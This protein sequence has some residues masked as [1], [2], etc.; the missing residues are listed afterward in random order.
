MS[1]SANAKSLVVLLQAARGKKLAVRGAVLAQQLGLMGGPRAVRDLLANERAGILAEL[2]PSVLICLPPAGYWL[3]TSTD[4]I[5][6]QVQQWAAAERRERER[7][8][9]FFASVKRAG[10]L[11]TIK[12][13]F[14]RERK[15]AA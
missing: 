15:E 14:R 3:A 8:R 7:K 12:G 1:L 6:E 11:G 10:L 5:A 4:E 13:L 9:L 2:A